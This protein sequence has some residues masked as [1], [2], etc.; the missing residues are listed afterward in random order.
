VQPSPVTSNEPLAIVDVHYDG[1]GARA[2]CVVAASWT[3]AAS[4][5]ERIAA[6]PSVKPYRPGAF[7]EREL[8]CI[9]AAL[10]LVRAPL[11]AVIVDGYVDLDAQG[12]PGLGAHLHAHLGGAVAVVGVAK[13]AFRG[14][15]FARSVIRGTSRSPLFVTSRGLDAADAARL[16][17]R[18]HGQHR[19][20]TLLARA[21]HLAR[22]LASPMRP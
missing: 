9:T 16:V 3:D 1:A 4:I 5:E 15:A 12:T 22:G 11:R 18:M 10:S 21:D 17:Q 20:P 14:A 7:Y 19:I 6:I 13:T 8:P 2:A